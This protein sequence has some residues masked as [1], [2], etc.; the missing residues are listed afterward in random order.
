ML[1]ALCRGLGTEPSST[2]LYNYLHGNPAGHPPL[3]LSLALS[4]KLSPSHHGLGDHS[5]EHPQMK[6]IC[7][8]ILFLDLWGG[9]N[10]QN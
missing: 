7:R 10:L 9:G 8:V 5:E 6:K 1:E 3:A 4:F 2:Y